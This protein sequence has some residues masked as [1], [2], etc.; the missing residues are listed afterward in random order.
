M[1]LQTADERFIHEFQRKKSLTHLHQPVCLQLVLVCLNIVF[2]CFLLFP[3][4]QK[5]MLLEL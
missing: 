4:V 2:R 1:Q 5:T 3:R